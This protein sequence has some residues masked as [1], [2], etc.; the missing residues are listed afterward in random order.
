MI[1][2]V[3]IFSLLEIYV[4]GKKYD[5]RKEGWKKYDFQCN[6]YRPLGLKNFVFFK[7]LTLLSELLY[8]NSDPQPW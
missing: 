3:L 4:R 6:I 2:N 8:S 1:K 5:L 7:F